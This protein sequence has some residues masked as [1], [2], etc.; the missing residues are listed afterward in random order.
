[1][2][3][4]LTETLAPSKRNLFVGKGWIMGVVDWGARSRINSLIDGCSAGFTLGEADGSG[5]DAGA[6]CVV[7]GARAAVNMA[8]V[9]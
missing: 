2:L 3:F 9:E 4:G 5:F 7:E 6:G 8:I 1:M